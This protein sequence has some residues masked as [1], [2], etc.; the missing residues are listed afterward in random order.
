MAN[1]TRTPARSSRDEK[2]KRPTHTTPRAS[3]LFVHIVKPDYGTKQYPDEEGSFNITLRLTEA[4]ADQLK[5]ALA[6]EIAEARAEMDEKFNELPIATRKKLG[7]PAWNE[8]GA[9]E[10][11]RETEEPTGFVLFRFKTKASYTDRQGETRERKIPVFDSMQQPV[12]LKDEPGFGSIVRVNFTAAPYFV[13]SSGNGGLTFY[14]NAVQILK[15]KE[16]GARSA[17]DYGFDM[18]DDADAFTAIPVVDEAGKR[19]DD[20]APAHGRGASTTISADDVPF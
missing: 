18:E 13:S 4:E 14:L 9:V 19:E 17:A 2:K 16:G 15:L 5:A 3:S 1:S 10:Y 12:K 20:L 8:P 7:Q 6:D 11:D